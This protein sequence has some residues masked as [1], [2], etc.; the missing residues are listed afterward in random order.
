MAFEGLIQ[1][2]FGWSFEFD[3]P[4][5]RNRRRHLWLTVVVNLAAIL[6]VY[7]FALPLGRDRGRTVAT[8]IDYTSAFVGYLGLATPNF[9]LALILFYYGHKYFNLPIG[10]P[11]G[12]LF[13]RPADDL[14]KAEIHPR[15]PD[16][17]DLRDRHVRRLGHDAAPARQYAG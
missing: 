14:G 12:P 6:F 17:A 5:R 3:R 11:D 16:R 4:V 10:G 8:W 7:A 1:G 13:R 2:N 15:P 9:L